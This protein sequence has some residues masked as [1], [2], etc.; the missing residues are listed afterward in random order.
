MAHRRSSAGGYRYYCFVGCTSH[1]KRTAPLEPLA[2]CGTA[3]K[4][5][6][7]CRQWPTGGH[8][9]GVIDVGGLLARGLAVAKA[10]LVIRP[11]LLIALLRSRPGLLVVATIGVGGTLSR[12]LDRPL[13]WRRKSVQLRQSWSC[14]SLLLVLRLLNREA[15]V[16]WHVDGARRDRVRHGRSL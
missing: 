12:L 7:G 9:W 4:T 6:A 14:L 2:G 3:Q 1:E 16:V 13:R 15:R 5:R 11:V 10:T 8:R